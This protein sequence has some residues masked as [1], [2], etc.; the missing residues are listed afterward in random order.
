MHLLRGSYADRSTLPRKVDV[1]AFEPPAWTEHALCAQIGG[2][3]WFPEVGA[4]TQARTARAICAD[5]PVRAQCLDY[6]LDWEVGHQTRAFGIYGGL[7]ERERR[8]LA[9]ARKD[10]S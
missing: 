7:S 2:D 9:Q 10:A 8:P 5:C 1:L 4:R 6:A 3:L